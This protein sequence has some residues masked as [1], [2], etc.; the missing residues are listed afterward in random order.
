MVAYQMTQELL[1]LLKA[2]LTNQN[3]LFDLARLQG[4]EEL[5]Q[6]LKNESRNQTA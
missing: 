4:K 2:D 5:L 6:E 1:S 3:T